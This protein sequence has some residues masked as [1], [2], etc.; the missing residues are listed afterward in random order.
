MIDQVDF[1]TGFEGEGEVRFICQSDEKKYSISIWEG[2]FFDIMNALLSNLKELNIKPTG[3]VYCYQTQTGW[4]D[5]SP[6][7][8]EDLDITSNYFELILKNAGFDE[9][10]EGILAAIIEL[11]NYARVNNLCVYIDYD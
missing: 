7:L 8:L 5:E 3:I 10:R 11:L 2:Y 4:Y 1:Y 9:K 6:W